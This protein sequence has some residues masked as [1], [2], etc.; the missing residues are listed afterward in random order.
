VKDTLQSPAFPGDHCF[1]YRQIYRLSTCELVLSMI[2]GGD[3]EWVPKCQV[4]ESERVCIPLD[5]SG[6][7][8]LPSSSLRRRGLSEYSVVV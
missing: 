8:G 3:P 5:G 6:G 2:E 1:R 7:A 4:M